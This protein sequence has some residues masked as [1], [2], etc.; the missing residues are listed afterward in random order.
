[1]VL[2]IETVGSRKISQGLYASL[3]ARQSGEVHI[4]AWQ[5]VRLPDVDRRLLTDNA[6]FGCFGVW[7][8]TRDCEQPL[9]FRRT[10][11]TG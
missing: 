1:M 3:F 7:C 4:P 5:N 2:I 11:P 6:A 9:I 8:C 10:D